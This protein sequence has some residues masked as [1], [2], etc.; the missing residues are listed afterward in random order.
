M[1]V[2]YKGCHIEVTKERMLSGNVEICFSVF[3]NAGYEI[4]SGYSEGKDSI[5]YWV[6]D[7]KEVVDEY[8]KN[9]ATWED[10]Y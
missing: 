9:P 1:K 7:L 10:A 5:K 2:N 8:L 6:S 3:T 4:T